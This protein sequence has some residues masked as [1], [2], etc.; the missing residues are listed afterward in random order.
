MFSR[1]PFVMRDLLVGDA[2]EG[3]LGKR[4][5][6]AERKLAGGLVRD[7]R[8]IP[9]SDDHEA[10]RCIEEVAFRRAL[11]HPYIWPTKLW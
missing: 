6:G 8:A 3:H 9:A 2:R 5:P 11:S 4:F 7:R 10:A 1:G